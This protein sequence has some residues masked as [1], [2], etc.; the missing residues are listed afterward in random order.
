MSISQ[1]INEVFDQI[2]KLFYFSVTG[3]KIFNVESLGGTI[4]LLK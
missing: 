2:H 4:L 3:S 1:M